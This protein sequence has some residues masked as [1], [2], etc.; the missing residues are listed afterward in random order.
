MP[1][2]CIL[3]VMNHLELKDLYNLASTCKRFKGLAQQTFKSKWKNPSLIIDRHSLEYANDFLRTFGPV[4]KSL[5]LTLNDGAN[6]SHSC[7]SIL[8]ALVQY[9]GGIITRL[10]LHN[11][12][13]GN[14]DQSI[15]KSR[16]LLVR[17]K[18]VILHNC[19]VSVKWF[20]QCRNLTELDLVNNNII[21]NSVPHQKCRSLTKLRVV[22]SP[23]W[24]E[25]GLPNFLRRNHQL[26][27][28]EV[29]PNIRGSYNVRPF[30]RIW[31]FIPTAIERLTIA[32]LA[33]SGR[34]INLRRFV[35][36]K[37]LRI[38]G[39]FIVSLYAEY[40]DQFLTNT[41]VDYLNIELCILN[42]V[43]DGRHI[44]AITKMTNLSTLRLSLRE[45]GV[46]MLLRLVDELEKLTILVSCTCH[47][48]MEANDLLRLVETGSSLEI[49]GISYACNGGDKSLEINAEVYGELM[50]VVS[51]RSNGKPLHIIIF[52][53]QAHATESNVNASFAMQP[54]LK[55][56][57]LSTEMIGEIMN[58]DTSRC[59]SR[60]TMTDE[61]LAELNDRHLLD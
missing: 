23:S 49:L 18:K 29:L 55:I 56:S 21:H 52:R 12:M 59:D 27:S 14:S 43:F 50:K 28:L 41:A 8:S 45:C 9:C 60:V 20:I 51:R 24:V 35:S 38:A 40:F 47:V 36:L 25:N 17:L 34:S 44:A 3:E 39:D 1:D 26:K 7:G 4:A 15:T 13:F 33:E 6:T 58:I 19:T 54:S 53:P 16:P 61:I 48:P 5:R 22:G 30:E 31:T 46:A 10:E 42:T 11:F 57:C 2:D 37:E 32:P